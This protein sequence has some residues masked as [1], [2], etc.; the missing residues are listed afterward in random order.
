MNILL[1]TKDFDLANIH[2][3]D[4]KTNTIIDGVFTKI[5]FSNSN[6]TMNG[7]FFDFVIKHIMTNRVYAKDILQLDIITNKDIVQK[8]IDIE[9]QLLHYYQQYFNIQ[10]KTM[11]FNL[12]NQFLNSSVKYYKSYDYSPMSKQQFFIKISGIWENN[13]EF[14]ITF[15]IIE[16][17]KKK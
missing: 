6:I 5:L 12:K 3:S 10:N 1:Q 13:N 16:Y 7:L 9:K 15:K 14:G 4:K 8:C 11:L 17:Y 2:F